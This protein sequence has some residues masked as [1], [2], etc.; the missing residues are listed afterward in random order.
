MAAGVAAMLGKWF[1][2]GDRSDA[3]PANAGSDGT[4]AIAETPKMF[5]GPPD[6][7]AEIIPLIAQGKGAHI[8]EKLDP[9]ESAALLEAAGKARLKGDA[10]EAEQIYG[11]LLAADPRNAEA[12]HGLGLLA[13]GAGDLA[14]AEPLICA[15]MRLD[16]TQAVYHRNFGQ[17]LRQKGEIE[18]AVHAFDE[19]ARLRPDSARLQNDRG[20]A[21]RDAG[22]IKRAEAAFRLALALDKGFAA[23]HW[24]LVCLELLCGNYEEGWKDFSWGFEA[25]ARRWSG[26][27][28]PQYDGAENPEAKVVLWGRRR[29]R[30][31]RSC[32]LSLCRSCAS[33]WPMSSS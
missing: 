28:L 27:P 22:R 14:K 13:L 11:R 29:P 21:L 6:G 3:S 7:P 16:P 32:R 10:A 12:V 9:D 24:N 1:R 26:L 2:R 15:S 4:E 20:E 23:A 25:R 8:A 30:L 19:A 33:A 17:L 5:E 18:A 31:A